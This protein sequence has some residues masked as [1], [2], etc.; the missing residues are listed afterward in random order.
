MA[1]TASSWWTCA[2]RLRRC[3][4]VCSSADVKLGRYG[5]LLRR[6]SLAEVPDLELDDVSEV[7]PPSDSFNG[8]DSAF[9]CKSQ[10]RPPSKAESEHSNVNAKKGGRRRR[11]EPK[12]PH[13]HAGVR[14]DVPPSRPRGDRRRPGPVPHRPGLPLHHRPAASRSQAP[15]LRDFLHSL[16]DVHALVADML[17]VCDL[18]VA[19]ELGIPGHLFFS[20]GA[21]SLSVFLQLP[22]FCSGRAGN[23][24]DLGDTPVSFPG[25]SPMPASHLVDAVLDR[26][27]DLY[28]T[29][30]DVFGRIAGGGAASLIHWCVRNP[31]WMELDAGG[32]GRRCANGVLAV[33]SRA[34][35]EQGVH[36]PRYE[37][38]DR[39]FVVT[40]SWVPQVE[41][42]RHSST[43]AFVTHCGWN[44][45]LEAVVAGVPMV[46]WPLVAEQWMNKV[47]IVQDMKVGVEVRGYKRGGLVRADDVDA[48]VRQIMDMEPERRRALEER[49][50]A[51]K[52]SAQAVWKEDGSSCTAFTEFM[53]QTE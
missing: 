43:G 13:L 45:T 31:L 21:A 3:D 33:G 50:M 32:G 19:T 10:T 39:G 51:V 12:P 49:I 20:T 41:V 30:L 42:L 25:M 26:G 27:T 48:A 22:L 28:A 2:L 47:Y 53:M 17:A 16:P 11:P 18:D 29:V 34:V 35:D 38:A 36:C 8:N 7:L 15:V 24:K 40:A 5:F 1:M 4:D 37:A 52:K 23:L 6:L 46:C 14:R 9:V 44:S